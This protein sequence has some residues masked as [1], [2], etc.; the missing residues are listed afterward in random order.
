METARGGG[1]GTTATATR[2]DGGRG[3]IINDDRTLVGEAY[4]GPRRPS[5]DG[6]YGNS[7]PGGG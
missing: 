5:G 2:Q 4:A 3:G 7:V 1:S 6:A